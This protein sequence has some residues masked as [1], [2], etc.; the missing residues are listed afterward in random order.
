MT[1][2]C[3]DEGCLPADLEER[4]QQLLSANIERHATNL[5]VLADK[6]EASQEDCPQPPPITFDDPARFVRDIELGDVKMLLGKPVKAI[7]LGRGCII[8]ATNQYFPA[9]SWM[10]AMSGADNESQWANFSD[11]FVKD[12]FSE[13]KEDT[14]TNF[15][16]ARMMAVLQNLFPG[17]TLAQCEDAVKDGK[18]IAVPQKELNV[19]RSEKKRLKAVTRQLALELEDA[20]PIVEAARRLH[21]A[22][23]TLRSYLGD[24]TAVKNAP[25]D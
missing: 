11:E 9:G 12:N 15:A 2:Y 1:N 25:Q 13:L 4:R 14:G 21:T 10:V 6:I 23:S 19:L 20:R 17:A 24:K 7:Q 22:Q 5:R 16:N 8:T 3:A 18:Y